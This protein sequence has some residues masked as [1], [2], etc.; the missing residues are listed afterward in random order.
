[1]PT[2]AEHVAPRHEQE[3]AR[4]GGGDLLVQTLRAGIRL[5]TPPLLRRR[6]HP[7]L[8]LEHDDVPVDLP[9]KPVQAVVL[10]RLLE[11]PP[12]RRVLDGEDRRRSRVSG[13]KVV[14]ERRQRVLEREAVADEEHAQPSLVA[15]RK[16]DVSPQGRPNQRARQTDVDE[17]GV[18]GDPKSHPCDSEGQQL[19]QPAHLP[20]I[21]SSSP[22]VKTRATITMTCDQNVLNIDL[23]EDRSWIFPRL[24]D[25]LLVAI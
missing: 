2:V 7:T 20:C 13:R 15:P 18:E 10:A 1:M 23:G 12:R 19:Q 24:A 14:H 3:S 25:T 9:Q 4:A 6:E 5:A 8:L 21:G 11:A 16:R 22:N 17:P